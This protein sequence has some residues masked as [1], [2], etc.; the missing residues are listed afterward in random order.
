MQIDYE[1]IQVFK[2]LNVCNDNPIIQFLYEYSKAD[3]D[4]EYKDQK[5]K[6]KYYDRL[7]GFF[8]KMT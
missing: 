8:E 4:E 3:K 1:D 6:E 7:K 2:E 5:Y